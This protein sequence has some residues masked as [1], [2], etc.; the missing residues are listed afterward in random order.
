MPHS[1][2]HFVRYRNPIITQPV[3]IR[4]TLILERILSRRDDKSRGHPHEGLGFQ[5]LPLT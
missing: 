2:V 1:L 3:G 4:F 5:R